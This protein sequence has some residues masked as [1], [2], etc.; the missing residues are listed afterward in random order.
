MSIEKQRKA[1]DK[2]D[3]QIVKLLNDRTKHVLEI[4]KAKVLRQSDSDQI[5]LVGAGVTLYEALEAAEGGRVAPVPQP[6]MPFLRIERESR[7][8]ACR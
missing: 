7:T 6:Q 4:G 3:A 1:I 2:I 5:T 8:R